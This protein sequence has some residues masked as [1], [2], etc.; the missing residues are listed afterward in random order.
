[1]GP[2]HA[3]STL[4]IVPEAEGSWFLPLLHERIPTDQTP[5]E[6]AAKQ[7]RRACAEVSSRP[8]AMGDTEYGWELGPGRAGIADR[9]RPW[10]KQVR[11]P[12]EL[13]PGQVRR[14]M[15]GVL[16]AM[17]TPAVS[18]QPRGK[19]PGRRTGQRPGRFER[20]PVVPKSHKRPERA[21]QAR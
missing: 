1:V 16:A 6:A 20:F 7:L 14:A 10:E 5:L 9:P 2:G 15:G 4:G 12:E 11:P 17:G 18:P 8:V 13:T 21:R 19:S 3:Y